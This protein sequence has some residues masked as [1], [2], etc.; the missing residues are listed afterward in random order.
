M[1]SL[2]LSHLD[3]AHFRN[4]DSVSLNPIKRF[5]VISGENGSGKTN[6]LESIYFFSI[7]R[8][9]RTLFRN[10]IPQEGF[11]ESSF[12]AL[13]GGAVAGLS[14]DVLLNATGRHIRIDGKE[15]SSINDHF[16]LLPMV[17]F[18]PA[19]MVLLQGGPKE[20][21]RYMDRALFQS[22]RSYPSILSD[23]NRALMS[24]NRLLKDRSVSR[25]LLSPFD[26]Q[27]ASLGSAIV[28]ARSDF[29]D[30]ARPIFSNAVDLIG[31]G[32]TGEMSYRPNLIGDETVFLSC[33]EQTVNRDMERGFTS[34]GPHSDDLTVTINCKSARRYASQGQ[35][36]IAVLSLKIAEVV[37]LS[38][39]TGKIPILI[40]DDISSE[41]DRERNRALFSFLS[42]VGGQV[43]ITTTHLDHVLLSD[44]RKDFFIS[45]GEISESA[46]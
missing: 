30:R 35:Q 7:L 31:Q 26:V 9:F 38:E 40:L 17:L 29:V 34:R 32:V 33:F 44:E 11:Q 18:H 43:F 22:V 15:L 27:L 23:Y 10:E 16:S 24:R 5:N 39:V 3:L 14:M 12:K 2:H 46:F 20:R 42:D 28:N 37:T 36:R 1:N 41:L 19:N 8:S 4:I 13:F 25:S 21:R 45:K 6:L